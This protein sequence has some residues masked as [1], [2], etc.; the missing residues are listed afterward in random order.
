VRE[1]VEADLALIAQEAARKD[2]GA[3]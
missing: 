1:M 3:E 2:R